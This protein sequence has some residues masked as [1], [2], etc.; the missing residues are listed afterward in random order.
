MGT[1]P[2]LGPRQLL[3][4]L[5]AGQLGEHRPASHRNSRHAHRQGTV[6]LAGRLEGLG[7][8]QAAKPTGR[9]SRC[10]GEERKTKEQ[11]AGAP[12]ESLGGRVAELN[13]AQGFFLWLV[14]CHLFPAGSAP[15]RLI[16]SPTGDKRRAAAGVFPGRPSPGAPCSLESHWSRED[17]RALIG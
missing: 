9:T 10:E 17:R 8:G 7:A 6:R 15:A 13:S 4:A 2:D 14:T 3:W 12:G 11:L 1:E 5:Q 16:P